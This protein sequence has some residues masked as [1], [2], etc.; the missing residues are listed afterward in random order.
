MFLSEEEEKA[1]YIFDIILKDPEK[2]L[3][4]NSIFSG[5][6]IAKETFNREPNIILPRSA[7]F[8][9]AYN[10]TYCINKVLS[11]LIDKNQFST[12]SFVETS[13]GRPDIEYKTNSGINIQIKKEKSKEKLPISSKHRLKRSANN[14]ILLDFGDN[15][16]EEIYM[17]VIFDHKAFNLRY[18]QIGIPKDDYSGW[19]RKWNLMAFVKQDQVE[20]IVKTNGP[21]IREEF[22]EKIN[23][24]YKLALRQG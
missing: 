16:D 5:L 23:K 7:Y 12:L 8:F 9:T 14:Q 1:Q 19:I 6:R 13:S 2:S 3:M 17:L 20:E 22:I 4:A 11:N 10:L 18:M 24:E 15:I 21:I